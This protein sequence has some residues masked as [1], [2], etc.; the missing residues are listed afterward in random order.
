MMIACAGMR[1]CPAR[2][3]PAMRRVDAERGEAELSKRTK[4]RRT[5]PRTRNTKR[6][7]IM[8]ANKTPSTCE[9]PTVASDPGDLPEPVVD[10]GP[11]FRSRRRRSRTRQLH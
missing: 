7:C 6:R 9:M 5:W 10:E 2:P 1:A 3:V 8:K 4:S 11:G